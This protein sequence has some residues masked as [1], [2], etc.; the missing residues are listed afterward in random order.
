MKQIRPGAFEVPEE[1]LKRIRA[2]QKKRAL[3]ARKRSRRTSK[4][5]GRKRGFNFFQ[6]MEDDINVGEKES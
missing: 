4:S 1:D 2:K 6:S 3:R 5:T